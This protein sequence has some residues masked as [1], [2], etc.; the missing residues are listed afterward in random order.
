MNGQTWLVA[1]NTYRNKVKSFGF[2]AM[3][4][5]PFLIAAVYLVIGLV[6]GSG[7]NQ[8]GKLAVVNN[9]QVATVLKADTALKT[10]IS[11]VSD[12]ETAKTDLSDGKIDGYLT[13]ESGKFTIVTTNKTSSKFNQTSFQTALT[14]LKM[15]GTAA[16]LGLSGKE[17]QQLLTP[18]SLTMKTQSASGT[19]SGGDAKIGANMGI[20]SITS[21][22]IFIL[23]MMYAGMVAQEIGNE[24]SNRI[25]ETLLAA[26]SSNVQY[27][28]KILGVILLTFTQLAFYALGFGIAYPFIKDLDVVKSLAT[29]VTGI[30]LGFGIYVLLMSLF[31]ILG[32]LFLASIIAS[33]VNEQ[34]QVQQAVQPLTFFAMIGYI[35]GITGAAVPGNIIL[36]VL[37][38][39]PFI[40]PTLMSSRYAIQFSS[41]AEAYI[42]L[43]LQILATIAVAKLGERIYARNVLSYSSEKIFS[44]LITNMTG[45]EKKNKS[46]SADKNFLTRKVSFMGREIGMWRFLVALLAIIIVLA[47]RFLLHN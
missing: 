41:T 23:L 39:I 38:F 27:Y 16:N 20:A 31:G 43:A 18:A 7:F 11:E 30:D 6:I 4:L 9:P 44:Q 21:I 46:V 10:N 15:Q 32:Y 34:A 26:T 22:L 36:R 14:Q 24:K 35:A 19:S 37:S 5:S 33:L 40:S 45:R 47:M 1:K 8:T 12:L 29:L 17:L 28:G 13:E 2:W 25:M 42:A 3:V